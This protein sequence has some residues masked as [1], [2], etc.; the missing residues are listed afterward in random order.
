MQKA[1]TGC[2]QNRYGK[3]CLVID[4]NTENENCT[5]KEFGFDSQKESRFI[6]WETPK[7][8]ARKIYLYFRDQ[9]HAN[10][11][12][13]KINYSPIDTDDVSETEPFQIQDCTLPNAS[14]HK[15]IEKGYMVAENPWRRL[16]YKLYPAFLKY[17]DA[18]AQCESDGTHL[19]VPKS[20][21]E[22]DFI[23]SL[24]DRAHPYGSDLMAHTWL[25]IDDLEEDG[26]H[27]TVDG[28]DLTFTK[29]WNYWGKNYKLIQGIPS[30]FAKPNEN[31]NAMIM[32]NYQNAYQER[33]GFWSV[34]N[35][36]RQNWILKFVCL[37]TED[38]M[39]E[40][41]FKKPAD[42]SV[43]DNPWGRSHYKIYHEP[44][45]YLEAQ[46]QCNSDGANLAIPRSKVENDFIAGL[47]PDKIIW[48]G[49]ND[50]ANEGNF[51]TDD[52]S[53]WF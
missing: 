28:S 3:I 43:A 45:S 34:I 7:K 35:V 46:D 47:I 24:V 39:S 9:R 49:I 38:F 52:G 12:D 13:L 36:N 21:V 41:R 17:K 20:A 2:C 44:K 10:I 50:I 5:D 53:G 18:K 4:D 1:D 19:P 51:V 42:Y 14:C 33:L 16:Y 27:K 8:V 32:L 15:A 40:K 23:S 30:E 31:E 48:I 25:G 26:N 37:E 22:N 29:W 6:K 11:A